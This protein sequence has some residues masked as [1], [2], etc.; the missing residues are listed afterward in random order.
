MPAPHL[1]LVFRI[2]LQLN[3]EQKVCTLNWISNPFISLRKTF[4]ITPSLCLDILRSQA[5]LLMGRGRMRVPKGRFTHS[6]PRPYRDHA[7][8]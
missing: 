7:V 6:M 5:L 1:H 8:R 3:I 2:K 4:Y